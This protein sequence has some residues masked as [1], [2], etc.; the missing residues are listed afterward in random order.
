MTADNAWLG[1]S[2][3]WRQ[4]A[5]DC[6][7]SAIC[8]V[9]TGLMVALFLSLL[10]ITIRIWWHNPCLLY[11]LPLSGLV[12]GLLYARG[13]LGIERGNQL[14]FEQIRGTEGRVPLRMAPLVLACTLL[15][16]LCGGSAGREGTAVQMGGSLS[17]GLGRRLRLSGVRLQTLLQSGIAAGFGAVFG[18]PAAG[19]IFA[20]EAPRTAGVRWHALL[21]TIVAAVV[22]HLTATFCGIR[23]A[24]YTIAPQQSLPWDSCIWQLG[25]ILLAGVTFAAIGRGY[26][27]CLHAVQFM[28]Q[29]WV[30]KTV[31]RP[32]SGAVLLILLVVVTGQTE[33]LS[34]GADSNPQQPQATTLESAFH[35]GGAGWWTWW[36]KLVFTAVTVGSGLRGGEVTPLFLMG[37]AAGHSFARLAGLPVDLLAG[38]G[39]VGVFGAATRAPVASLVLGL[40]LFGWQGML[41]LSGLVVL[42]G[43]LQLLGFLEG[44][45]AGW[46]KKRSFKLEKTSDSDSE[47]AKSGN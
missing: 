8:G 14:I 1:K 30:P 20:M 15:T 27:C 23:H 39:F 28:Q 47:S 6:L 11:C 29:R 16:H 41:W 19:V 13:V 40:E 24:V 42:Q 22:G 4:T 26:E 46:L 5:G 10:Q 25:W 32:V 9:A 45:I 2:W 21:P 35:P 38:L 17:G 12:S 33:C 36:W 34:L 3:S 7:W 44:G 18:T 37:A 43:A 31:L